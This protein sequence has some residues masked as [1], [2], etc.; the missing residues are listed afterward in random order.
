MAD[1]GGSEAAWL[2]LGQYA[3]RPPFR[4][5]HARSERWAAM[6]C[7]RRAGKTVACVADLV[8]SALFTK[9]Q[10]ARFAYVAPQ[11]NQAKDIAW[12]YVQRLTTDIQGC[13]YNE[14]ELRVDFP[15]GARV[16]LYGA[17]NPDRLRG[18]Y[19]D[20]VIM[21]EYA[22]MRPSVWGEVIRPLLADRQGWAVFIGTPKGRNE[23]FRIYEAAKFDPDWFAMSLRASE[24]GLIAESE[25]VASARDMT[26]EQYAQE[27]ECSFDAAILGAYY[28][29][30]IAEAERQGRL[31]EVPVDPHAP[32]HTAWDLGIGD[33]TAIW[34]FQV[35]GNEVHVVDFYENHSYGLPHYAGVLAAKGYHYGEDFV[36]H[37]AKVREW[38]TGRTRIEQLLDLKRKPRVVPQETIEDGIN[39]VRKTLPHVY[40]DN[41]RCAQGI[42]ALRQYRTDYDEKVR[43]FK[44][45]PLHDWTSHAADAFRYLALGWREMKAAPPPPKPPVHL[46]EATPEGG[47]K[48]NLTIRE[49][50]ERKSRRRDDD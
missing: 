10:D 48:S 44:N 17:D 15:N 4:R 21:D 30:D 42:E 50:I 11:F 1:G 26:P 20:G 45:A 12:I 28:G 36:P 38:G 14:T 22:D 16:R 31:R 27:W 40:F 5:F 49:L 6:V 46:F 24:S 3:P 19:L 43:A 9:K 47:V 2:G 25:L 7:H 37:D 35:A 34:F 13:A 8:C 39:A 23:F 33:S 18:L 41:I 32:V 29:R